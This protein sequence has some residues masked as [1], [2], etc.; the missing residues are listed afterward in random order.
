M[1]PTISV[2]ALPF[3]RAAN[4]AA[5]ARQDELS[6]LADVLHALIEDGRLERWQIPCGRC[7]I[8]AGAQVAALCAPINC[9]RFCVYIMPWQLDA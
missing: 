3:Q 5:C 6:L 8:A 2:T 7:D 9:Q 4:V 1:V